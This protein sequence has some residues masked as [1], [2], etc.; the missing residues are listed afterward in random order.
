MNNKNKL[1]EGKAKIIFE[2]DQPNTLIQYFKDDATAFNNKKKGKIIGKGKINNLISEFLMKKISE[3][4]IKTHFI[5][6]ISMREQIIHKLE[7]IPIEV[8][9]RNIATG[10]IVKRLGINEGKKFKKPIIEFYLKNDLLNDP[11]IS[12]EHIEAFEWANKDEIKKIIS[13]SNKI[14]NFLL[15]F[16]LKKN[17]K[18]IDF[19][20][21]FGRLFENKKEIIIADEISP[22]NCRLWDLDTNKKLD[23]DRFRQN[24]GNVEEAYREI[25]NRLG[26]L[27]SKELKEE[28]LNEI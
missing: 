23:K 9:I 7:I 6:R 4:K 17:I 21:E 11:I 25:A 3:L 1:F 12:Q 5:K 18:L 26:V 16:F 27:S 22:D 2:G 28:I 8:V 24:L 13:I 10:S 14:N 15:D 19:K 20:L